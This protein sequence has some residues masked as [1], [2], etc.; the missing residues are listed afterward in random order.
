MDLCYA[1]VNTPSKFGH[2]NKFCNFVYIPSQ[3][4]PAYTKW[5]TPCQYS[6][7]DRS[8]SRCVLQPE[9]HPRADVS[10]SYK[11]QQSTCF[12][13]NQKAHAMLSSIHSLSLSQPTMHKNHLQKTLQGAG[14]LFCGLSVRF[15][16]WGMGLTKVRTDIPITLFCALSSAVR[17]RRILQPSVLSLT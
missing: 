1:C 4:L 6:L 15:M 2:A 16:A 9:Q 14:K 11:S 7:R 12:V 3:Q 13:H 8:R 10:R 17:D 5:R